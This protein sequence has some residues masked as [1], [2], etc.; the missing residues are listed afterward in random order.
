[1][2]VL[3]LGPVLAALCRWSWQRL[4]SAAWRES[5]RDGGGEAGLVLTG[6]GRALREGDRAGATGDR[7]RQGEERRGSPG[8]A[9]LLNDPCPSQ[10]SFLLLPGL[11]GA[12]GTSPVWAGC[13][14][15]QLLWLTV[16]CLHLCVPQLSTAGL[17]FPSDVS[18]PGSEVGF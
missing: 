13:V 15:C 7:E 11:E 1:M 3:P 2:W 16:L 17:A 9:T 8:L 5:E 14:P 4:G 6:T 18:A 12:M 10:E